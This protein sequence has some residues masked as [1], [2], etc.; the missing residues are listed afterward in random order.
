MMQRMAHISSNQFWWHAITYL[1]KLFSDLCILEKLSRL[2]ELWML[3]FCGRINLC[4][5]PSSIQYLLCLNHIPTVDISEYCFELCLST[6]SMSICIKRF[7]YPFF[8]FFFYF[9]QTC[10]NENKSFKHH[11][12]SR[13]TT[14]LLKRKIILASS[15]VESLSTLAARFV[16]TTLYTLY[17]T[18]CGCRYVICRRS[19]V[20]L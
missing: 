14:I 3:S 15:R 20:Q 18:I 17:T 1:M 16:C 4:K 6:L 12:K 10:H 9:I 11:F 13:E 2:E 7:S 5:F 19:C 8:F